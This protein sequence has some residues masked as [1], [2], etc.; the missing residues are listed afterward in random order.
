MPD[1][2]SASA[3]PAAARA[4]QINLQ[5][6]RLLA[7]LVA[8]INALHV[9]LFALRWHAA[10]GVVAAW[11]LDL[12]EAH[13]VM[14]LVMIGSGLAAHRQLGRPGAAEPSRLPLA[15]A[16]LGL[17]FSV[18]LVAIDQQVT[19]GISAFLVGCL[20]VSLVFYLPPVSALALAGVAFVLFLL[21]LG[22]GHGS[23]EQLLSNRVNGLS[24][25]AMGCALALLQWRHFTIITRQQAELERANEALMAKQAELE[26]LARTDGLTGLLNRVAFEESAGRELVRARREGNDTALLI[27]DLDHFK[28][29]NDSRGHAAGDAVLRHVCELFVARLRRSDLVGRLG[30][31][32]FV[33]LLPATAAAAARRIAEN[34]REALEATPTPWKGGFI[35]QTTSIGIAAAPAGSIGSFELL[36]VE[37]DQ[38]LYRAKQRGRNRVEMEPDPLRA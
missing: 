16:V 7:P 32:E 37:A 10:S 22:D 18:V 6:L 25:C 29:I 21:V 30:G 13:G 24:A 17:V 38:M 15:V 12:V 5:R 28:R 26:R 1:W 27:V 9:L 2:L 23:P 31:E 14:G 3:G 20:I 36:C 11:A 34:L 4:G 8:T 33:I 19:T 35:A